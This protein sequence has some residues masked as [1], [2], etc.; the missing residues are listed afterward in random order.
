MCFNLPTGELY[1]VGRRAKV[2]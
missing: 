2:F 1:Y